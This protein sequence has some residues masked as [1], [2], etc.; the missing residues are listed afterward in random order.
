MRTQKSRNLPSLLVWTHSI[1]IIMLALGVMAVIS[2]WFMDS[3]AVGLIF[4]R[5]FLINGI[6]QGLYAFR[7]KSEGEFLRELLPSLI[8]LIAVIFLLIYPLTEVLTL[9]LV[10]GIFIFLDGVL[11]VIQAFQ[12]RLWPK[13]GWVLFN[14]I[15][16]LILGFL[17]WSQWPFDALWLLGLFVGLSL[18]LNGMTLIIFSTPVHQSL[19]KPN[20]ELFEV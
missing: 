4:A 16:H 2:P 8:S 13:W 10:L 11:R 14:G 3:I 6:V 18:S 17:I 19:S 9:T 15:S 20:S 7:A 5:L 1:G 12:L